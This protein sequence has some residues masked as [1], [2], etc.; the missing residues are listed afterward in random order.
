MG[1]FFLCFM[2]VVMA[3]PLCTL[4]LPFFRQQQL[5]DVE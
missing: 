1:V 3:R 4:L 5:G 2:Y